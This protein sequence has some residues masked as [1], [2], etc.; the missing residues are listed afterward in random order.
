M[1]P[2]SLIDRSKPGHRKFLA[3]F[4]VNP[5]LRIISSANIP[6]QREDWWSDRKELI[7]EL[8]ARALPV[9]LQDMVSEG[10]NATSISPITT[11]EAKKYRLELMEERKASESDKN[12]A[13]E[14]GNFNLCEQSIYCEAAKKAVLMQ[15]QFP[16]HIIS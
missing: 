7:G 11:D 13:F 2:F 10:I 12:A 16:F 1:S 9:E 4:L 8:L 15:S 14:I 5:Y 6:P 3:F